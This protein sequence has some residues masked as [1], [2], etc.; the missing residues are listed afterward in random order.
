M[1]G[2]DGDRGVDAGDCPDPVAGVGRDLVQLLAIGAQSGA[3]G[4]LEARRLGVAAGR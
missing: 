4:R 3:H 2:Q 1:A